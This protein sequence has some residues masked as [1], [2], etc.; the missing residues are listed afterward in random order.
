[1]YIQAM[2]SQHRP[3]DDLAISAND[4]S[5]WPAYNWHVANCRRRTTVQRGGSRAGVED[6]VLVPSS[7]R[8]E[9]L[10]L[11]QAMFDTYALG[12]SVKDYRGT[13]I[14]IQPAI[15]TCRATTAM[16]CAS[17]VRL[18]TNM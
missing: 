12:W 1:M 11:T 2:G 13:K 5:K 4:M 18:V 3:A 17:R 16:A 15:T 14:N 9:I 10:K 8:S 7:S 6:E